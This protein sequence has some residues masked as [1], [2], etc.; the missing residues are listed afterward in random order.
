LR[1]DEEIRRAV[2]ERIKN[3]EEEL[4]PLRREAFE[5]QGELSSRSAKEAE[6][7]NALLRLEE[8]LRE[9]SLTFQELQGRFQEELDPVEVEKELQEVKAKLQSL[10]PVNL[11]A[12]EEHEALSERHRFLAAQAADLEA[13]IG[14]LKN[15]IAEIEKTIK[16]LFQETLTSV[17]E[18]FDRLWQ[19]LFGGGSATLTLTDPQDGDEP[20][21]E[22]T[23]QLP[24]R[25]K[26]PSSLLSGG[27]RSLAALAF[28]LALFK[29]KPSP[30]CILDEVDAPLDD[31]NVERFVALLQELSARHQF[32]VITHN[33][34]TMEAAE[35]LYG[36]TMEDGASKLISVKLK[37]PA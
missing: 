31:A 4:K 6:L 22:M 24:G 7:Q 30:F 36:L 23:L 33:K 12:L 15:T 14:T 26:T 37:D 18:H 10:G 28:L 34:K 32:I 35:V 17:N 1:R 27:E 5:L 11:A 3:L 25:R 29:V 16:R 2:K 21:L 13:S 8:D 19:C 9:Y 20:G